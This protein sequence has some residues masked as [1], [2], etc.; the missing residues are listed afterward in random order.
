VLEGSAN[1]NQRSQDG[2]RDVEI[3]MGAYQPNF[4]PAGRGVVSLRPSGSVLH[5]CVYSTVAMGA[6]QPNFQPAGRGVVSLACPV[7]RVGLPARVT[8]AL[9]AFQPGMRWRHAA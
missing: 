2:E 1:I 6:F 8:P 9:N 4:Q 5:V 7:V 3:A